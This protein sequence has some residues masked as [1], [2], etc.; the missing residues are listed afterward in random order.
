MAVHAGRSGTRYFHIARAHGHQGL[1][2]RQYA[3]KIYAAAWIEF[4]VGSSRSAGKQ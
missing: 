4:V 2:I 3:L 1:T